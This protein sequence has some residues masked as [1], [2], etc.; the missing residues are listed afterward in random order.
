MKVYLFDLVPYGHHF[1]EFKDLPYPLPG[2]Y[3]DPKIAQRNYAEHI[4]AWKEMDRLG[5]DGVG[6]NEHHTT[7]HGMMNSPNVMVGVASQHT[8]NLKFVIMGHLLP[9]HNP[10]RIAEEALASLPD[11]QLRVLRSTG[12][13]MAYDD[14]VGLARELVAFCG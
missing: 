8:K 1:T 13:L 9:M 7:P 5:F 14:P 3:F 12:F 4:E 11:G 6:F 2:K 10:L